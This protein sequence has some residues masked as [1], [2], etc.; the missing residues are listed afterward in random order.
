MRSDQELVVRLDLIEALAEPCEGK[1]LV[2]RSLTVMGLLDGPRQA[3]HVLGPGDLA[4]ALQVAGIC[5][6]GHGSTFGNRTDSDL[7]VRG[8]QRLTGRADLCIEESARF[9]VHAKIALSQITS[10]ALVRLA[11]V[12]APRRTTCEMTS[13]AHNHRYIK[14]RIEQR[15]ALEADWTSNNL[16]RQ[17][18]GAA[19]V[20]SR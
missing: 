13:A 15:Q 18:S 20:P 14:S 6:V 7:L 17:A 4:L 5:R 11:E 2:R 8:D 12:S 19:A 9:N 16:V 1:A 10:C 3:L